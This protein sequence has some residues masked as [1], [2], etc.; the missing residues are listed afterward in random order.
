MISA[1]GDGETILPGGG[2][3]SLGGI[4]TSDSRRGKIWEDDDE[5][6]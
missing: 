2:G 6:W 1:S 4:T 3:S 5:D